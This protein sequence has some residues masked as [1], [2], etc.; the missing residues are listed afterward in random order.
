VDAVVAGW[1]P[2]DGAGAHRHL[3]GEALDGESGW[4]PGWAGHLFSFRSDWHENLECSDY[5]TLWTRDIGGHDSR[6]LNCLNWYQA[7]AF[8]IW[9]GGFLPTDAELSYAIAGG[10]EQL[11]YPW[12]SAEPTPNLAIYSCMGDPGAAGND[13]DVEVDLPT[14]GSRSP[15][16]DG[17][18]G[19]SD[20]V[21][22]VWEWALDSDAAQQ[23]SC[24]DCVRGE[25]ASMR[26]IR[27]GG[28][29]ETALLFTPGRQ[30][31][32]PQANASSVGARCA[33][34]P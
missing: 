14:P 18:W 6:P 4:N 15:Q 33:R 2:E 5:E 1:R 32:E 24:N 10:N 16:G 29:D 9:D 22:S 34:T 25:A 19:Q 12:G 23:A 31:L 3:P 27:G 20:L 28:W 26:T 13:C 21:G 7:Y 30:G 17:R 8:C 11:Q